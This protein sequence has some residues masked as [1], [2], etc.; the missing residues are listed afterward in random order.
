M[1]M[2]MIG[3]NGLTSREA[4]RRLQRF[5][6]NE[7][8]SHKR[9]SML[10][11]FLLRFKNPL[12]IILMLAATISFFMG[13]VS[14]GI[15]ILVI[16]IVSTTIDF[17]NSY[18]SGKA[19]A[20]L[21]K[22]VRVNANVMRDGKIKS[23]PIANIVPGDMVVLDAG[24]LIP[25]DGK[26]IES[27]DL[28]VD[29]SSLTGESYPAMKTVDM[30]VYMGSS[31]TSG[32]GR[33]LITETG[34]STEFA[35]VAASVN[36]TV[37]TEFELEITKFSMLIARI[38]MG[39]V[40]FILAISLLFHR[41][42]VDAL[43]FSLALAV[44]LTPEL[45]P[46]IITVNLTKGS[47]RMA[48][49]GV[50]IK[51]LAAIQNMG[52]MDLLCTDKTG[53]LTE[54]R[55]SVAGALDFNGTDSVQTLELAAVA[56]EFTTSYENPLDTAILNCRK[57]DFRGY[58]KL[59]EIPFDFLRKR[60]SVVVAIKGGAL[61]VTK[62]AADTMLDIVT[63][64][65]DK[66]GEAR[67]LSSAALARL[68]QLYHRLSADGY[69]VL[70][71][72]TRELSDTVTH[73]KSDEKEMTF[74]GFITF[75][76][77]PKASARKSLLKLAQN[78]VGIKIITGDDPL[79]SV[80]VATELGLKVEG[81]LTGDQ[82]SKLNRLQLARRA[83]HTT[84]FARVNPS[85]KLAVIEALRRGGHVVGYMGDGINDAPSLRAADVGI[86]VNNAV[87][88]AKD[89]A[90]IILLGRSLSYINDGVVE[91][92]K[93]F[94]NTMKYLKMAL[95]SNFGNMFSMA[96]ASLF[97][98]FLPMTAP[99]ILFNNLLYDA[100]QFAIPSDNVDADQLSRPRRMDLKAIK[101]FMWVFGP[102]S[103][104]FDFTTF[105]VLLLLFHASAGEF[106][107]G[108]FIESLLTQ[109]LVVFI[110][111]THHF[112]IASRPAKALL[113][114]VIGVI[115][116]ALTVVFSVVGSYFGFVQ[117]PW[118]Q[119]VAIVVIVMVYLV[120]AE[121]AKQIFYRRVGD[122]V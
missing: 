55:I 98:P 94:A 63:K 36:R 28:T 54:N 104:L 24:S 23:V 92:R 101:K 80:K 61:L 111:R 47:L 35:R 102:L 15:I 5:G 97:L 2:I 78:N 41:N 57:Y 108:W 68:Q 103:S 82:I 56:C 39:L 70:A 88:V 91:G 16:V 42:P 7:I 109:T 95:S 46:L 44:G 122:R 58:K 4:R 14:S 85:Q 112:A 10:K 64:Y 32:S 1:V 93:T 52:S 121:S 113:L 75:I 96:G 84:I 27:N 40:L 107:T 25:A 59:Q 76:D 53:T 105:A 9:N 37:P 26:V 77:P 65:R 74:E 90:D 114:S 100:S 20:E 116:V 29:E 118:H 119:M 117:Q 19:A 43:L 33:I 45:L 62:G 71:I 49:K 79:V 66:N 22:S 115:I 120:V 51:K 21:Q 38:T 50:I 12:V 30:P 106:Q 48:K 110:F 83:E 3:V 86:S 67:S 18:Q 72:A 89:T 73:D 81:V 99:Q 11:D 8:I 34:R 60:E 31:V 13:E 87:D 6:Y 17:L 69:R